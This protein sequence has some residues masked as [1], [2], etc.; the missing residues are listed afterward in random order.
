[1]NMIEIDGSYGEGGGQILRTSLSLAA[2]TGTPVRLERIRARRPKP[3]LMRQHL[4]CAEAVAAICGGTLDGGVLRSQELTLKPGRIR[5]GDYRFAIGSAG[6]T[7]LL[8]QTILPVLL[9]AD[10]PSRVVLE[11]GTH[12]DKAPVFEFFDRVFLPCLRQMGVEAEATLER[13]GF[14]PVGGGSITLSVKPARAWRPFT[15]TERGELQEAR[16]TAIGSGLEASI[17]HDELRLFQ[18]GLA[19]TMLFHSNAADV[20]SPGPGNVLYAEL[21]YEH[22][23]ELFSVCGAYGRSREV[24]AREAA[25]HV[26]RYLERGWVA[27]PFLADQLLLPLALGAGGAYLTGAPTPHTETNREVIRRFLGASI[28]FR[29]TDNHLTQV[30]ISP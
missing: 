25:R 20:D 11:G 28:D 19:E 8:A 3:G 15:L 6:S 7:I 27:G 24:V 14:C 4:T 12:V 17:L 22:I 26:R 1:M 30:E 13:V 21:L 16:V 10:A 18:A 5:G 9:F 2:I 29:E 23:H